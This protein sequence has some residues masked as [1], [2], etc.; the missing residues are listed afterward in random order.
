MIK[1]MKSVREIYPLK[2]LWINSQIY[3]N[4]K[5]TIP[6]NKIGYIFVL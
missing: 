5:N 2:D 6:D 4:I 1:V 3:F